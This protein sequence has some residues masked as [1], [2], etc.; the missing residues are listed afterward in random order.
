LRERECE[1]E[2]KVRSSRKSSIRGAPT[3]RTYL[4]V[5]CCESMWM[6]EHN[7]QRSMTSWVARKHFAYAIQA[8]LS[9][10]TSSVISIVLSL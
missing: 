1:R 9:K 5:W 8:M 10:I 3:V 7:W 4:A 2:S 6:Y